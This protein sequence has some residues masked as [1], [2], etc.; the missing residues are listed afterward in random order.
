MGKNEELNNIIDKIESLF[1]DSGDLFNELMRNSKDENIKDFIA[2]IYFNIDKIGIKKIKSLIDVLENYSNLSC[3][4]KID[5]SL[6]KEL[7]FPVSFTISYPKFFN[8]ETSEFELSKE[9]FYA[10]VEHKLKITSDE[11]NIITKIEYLENRF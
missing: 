2:G 10:S 11:N 7:S 3:G 9:K 8:N 6:E 4:D 1:L 5:N